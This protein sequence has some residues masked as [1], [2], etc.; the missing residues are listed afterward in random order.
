V[1]KAENK[2]WSEQ[3]V[4]H[5]GSFNS[6]QIPFWAKKQ[7]IQEF[8]KGSQSCK[9]LVWKDIHNHWWAY[10]LS[11]CRHCEYLKD[12]KWLSMANH[13][14]KL[15]NSSLCHWCIWEAAPTFPGMWAGRHDTYEW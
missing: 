10:H 7:S 3:A 15:W 13:L 14:E 8:V 6:P 11:H 12:L 9:G 4:F 2:V 5:T 1:T